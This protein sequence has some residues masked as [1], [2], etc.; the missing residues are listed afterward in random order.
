MF[1]ISNSLAGFARSLMPWAFGS[2]RLPRPKEEGVKITVALAS[3]VIDALGTKIKE[4]FLRE[5]NKIQPPP[6]TGFKDKR[7]DCAIGYVKKF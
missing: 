3:A 7:W 1:Q 5:R 6:T 4:R 2:L